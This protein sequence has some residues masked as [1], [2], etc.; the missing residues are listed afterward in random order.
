MPYVKVLLLLIFTTSFGAVASSDNV[1]I[2]NYNDKIAHCRDL[3]VRK[4]E[5]VNDEYFNTLTLEQ[6]EEL[7]GYLSIKARND[8]FAYEELQYFKYVIHTNDPE[9]LKI[10][11]IV[12]SPFYSSGTLDND[13]VMRLSKTELFSSPFDMFYLI[14]KIGVVSGNPPFFCYDD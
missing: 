7:I 10:I 3:G 5:T 1:V 2:K 6:K 12:S 14:D 4:I 8:C 13:E 9:G 11:K